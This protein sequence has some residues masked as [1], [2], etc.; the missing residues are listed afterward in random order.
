MV[1]SVKTK[2]AALKGQPFLRLQKRLT[3]V[4]YVNLSVTV[5]KIKIRST[6]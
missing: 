5:L 2:L 3:D 4:N 1:L 6:P